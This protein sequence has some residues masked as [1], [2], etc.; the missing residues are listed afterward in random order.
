[1]LTGTM[2]FAKNNQIVGKWTYEATDL[3]NSN[4]SSGYITITESNGKLS[5]T[6]APEETYETIEIKDIKKKGDK[7]EFECSIENEDIKAQL[8]LKNNKLS[9]TAKKGYDDLKVTGKKLVK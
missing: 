7:I 4:V 1:M 6:L 5:C 9:G 2:L 3:Y 8:K